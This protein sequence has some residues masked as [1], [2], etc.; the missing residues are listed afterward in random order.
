MLAAKD[1]IGTTSDRSPASTGATR[2]SIW[3]VFQSTLSKRC[4]ESCS[5]AGFWT[6]Q[7]ECQAG[8]SSRAVPRSQCLKLASTPSSMGCASGNTSAK[9]LNKGMPTMLKNPSCRYNSWCELKPHQMHSRSLP[10]GYLSRSQVRQTPEPCLSTSFTN[11]CLC[12]VNSIECLNALHASTLG[13]LQTRYRPSSI[14]I[15]Y[16]CFGTSL[17]SRCDA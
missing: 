2:T 11:A 4:S 12:C 8:T 14:L 16:F 13:R 17:S 15:G 7:S 5:D 3:Q 1:S 6:D 10:V 9:D